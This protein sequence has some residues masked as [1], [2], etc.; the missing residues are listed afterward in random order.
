MA[1]ATATRPQIDTGRNTVYSKGGVVVSISPLAATAGINVLADGG[2]A[3]DA[4]V[5][6]AAVEAVTVPSACGVGGEP[7]VIMYEVSTGEVYGLNGSGRAPLA[8]NHEF[9]IRQGHRHMPLEGPLAAAIPG[10]TLA[11]EQ[12]VDRFGSRSLSSLIEPA[13]GYAAEGF[14]V[15][16][17]LA[18]GFAVLNRKLEQFP[19]S[20]DI[21]TI[22]GRPLP[23]GHML[24]QKNLAMTLGRI[25][26]EGSRAFYEGEIAREMAR[27]IQAAG[28]LYT[29]AEFADHETTWYAPPI[30]STYR[31]HTVYETAPPS[32]G[33]ALLEILNILEGYDLAGMGFYT[34]ESV[35]TMVEAKKLAFADRN[36][37]MG[38]PEFIDSPIDELISKPFAGRRRQLMEQTAGKYE[39]GPVAMPVLGDDNTSYFCVVD[40][41]GNAV[42][43]IHSLSMGFGGGFVAGSTGVLLNNRV[44]RGFSLVEGHPN[45]IEGGKR[46]MH[47]LNAYMIMREDRPYVVGGT[48]GGDRQI[49]WNSQVI[50]NVLDHG[51]SAQEAVE[52][53]RWTSTPGTDPHNVDDPFVLELEGG[54][55]RAEVETLRSK[56]HDAREHPGLVYGGSAKLIVI[57][58]ATGVRTA[59]SDP[60]TDGHAVVV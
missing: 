18:R 7:F 43:F 19:D 50:S 40:A 13:I 25:A 42:S 4:A 9:F 16:D 20:R 2:N 31:G 54:M 12:I 34:A 51:M 39:A 22:D 32:Q 33:Y 15:S 44:G 14:A 52:A 27:A 26:A 58:P 47:T 1:V 53:P 17:E 48:P 45:V 11:W 28:G 41:Q 30:S 24:V 37:Y 38:D 23:P 59:G 36:R 5:A 35:H 49:G 60:R 46:T 21:F 3:F 6:T 57:D 10:E 29:E 8:A 56:G 55:S